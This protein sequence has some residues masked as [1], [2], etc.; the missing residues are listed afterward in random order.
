MLTGDG[1]FHQCYNAQAV[2]DEDHQVIVC[3]RTGYQRLRCGHF[4]IPMTQQTVANAGQAPRQ[5]LADAGYCSAN[6]LH[7]TPPTQTAY[8][9]HPRP[10]A[11]LSRR[12][13]G[14]ISVQFCSM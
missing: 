1:A 8:L 6:K 2:V 13:F 9:S 3:Y 5:L 4:P 10:A 11:S 7:P 14:R 12:L